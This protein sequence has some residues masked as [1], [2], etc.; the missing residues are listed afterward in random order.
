MPDLSHES[1]IEF[2]KNFMGGAV[3]PIIEFIEHTESWVE[4]HNPEIEGALTELGNYLDTATDAS[5]LSEI[6]LVRIC[7]Y[8]HLSQKLRIMQLVD[9]I[10]PGAATKMIKE[11]EKSALD[12]GCAKTFLQRN[13]V[14]ERMRISARLFSPA[15]IQMV[16]KIY[17]S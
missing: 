12:D 17:E 13:L 6:D 9:S 5:N 10:A 2:W 4:S 14:F 11:A 7:A 8:L 15:R 16:Q 3:L 1:A